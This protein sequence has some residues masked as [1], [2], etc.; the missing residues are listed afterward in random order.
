MSHFLEIIAEVP[1]KE[2]ANRWPPI[3][4]LTEGELFRAFV[5]L[6]EH[7]CPDGQPRHERVVFFEVFNKSNALIYLQPLLAH[8]WV[9]DTSD[10]VKHGYIHGI[11]LVRT[12]QYNG[13]SENRDVRVFELD[14]NHKDCIR[15]DGVYY[16][17][18]AQVDLFTSPKV[19][20]RLRQA[21]RSI[22]GGTPPVVHD[23]THAALQ[24]AIGFISG[25]EEDSYQH[26]PGVRELIELLR[27]ATNARQIADERRAKWESQQ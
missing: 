17:N 11:E 27:R 9:Q 20:I 16:A 7:M 8:A 13:L 1:P 2:P 21:L 6:P 18:P 19:Q 3:H 26:H 5:T 25:F 15:R 22:E 10:W 24:A 4:L 12:R 14:S 23:I